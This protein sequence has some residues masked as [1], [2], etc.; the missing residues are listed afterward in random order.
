MDWIDLSQDLLSLTL[1]I[2]LLQIQDTLEWISTQNNKWVF[3]P[4]SSGLMN[5]ELAWDSSVDVENDDLDE[6]LPLSDKNI[7]KTGDL[8][9]LI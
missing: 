7:Q 3:H 4:L 8:L 2:S 6:N 1:K 5:A 9:T